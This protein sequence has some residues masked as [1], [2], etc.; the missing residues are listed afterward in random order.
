MKKLL[1]ILLAAVLCLSLTVTVFAAAEN[2]FVLDE[3]DLLSPSEE[4]RIAERLQTISHTHNAQ[5][6]VITVP[7][8]A[9]TSVDDLVEDLYDGMG[10]GYGPA[11]DGV[12]LLVCMNPRQYRILS[13]GF[14]ADAITMDRIDDIGDAIVSDLSDGDYADAFHTF[15]DRCDYYLNGHLNGFPF[16]FGQNLVIALVI[17]LLAGLITALVLKSQLKSVRPQHQADVY[18]K[19]GS[20]KLT[21]SH[22]LYLY[23]NVTRTKRESSSG[24]SRSGSS[25]NIGGGSF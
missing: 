20:M 19:P 3:A 17:G 9:G 6:T 8:A 14:A 4:A 7:N 13:N 16:P 23:R 1:S 24:S 25:R 15:A 12:L 21:A 2:T 5:V 18:M 11:H 22:D 10:L